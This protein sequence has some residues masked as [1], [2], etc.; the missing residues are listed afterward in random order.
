M[1]TRKLAFGCNKKISNAC[2]LFNVCISLLNKTQ[3]EVLIDK[4]SGIYSF[5][6][7]QFL[8]VDINTA[9]KFFSSPK[10][11]EKI[12]P[13]FMKFDITSDRIDEIYEGQII[14][15]KIRSSA[16]ARSNWV[17]RITNL[18]ERCSFTDEQLFGPYK[19]WH[20]RHEFNEVDD[21]VFMK[22]IVHYKLP[23]AIITPLIEPYVKK[24]LTQI[25]KFRQEVCDKLFSE[26]TITNSKI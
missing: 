20:H 2:I 18:E 23:F 21:G 11:L 5:E 17:T 9:W 8:P 25:F 16:F 24:K 19:F 13:P 3:Q 7:E 26:T 1:I 6:V 10:N 4:N 14:T 12:T 22:D 15:Y